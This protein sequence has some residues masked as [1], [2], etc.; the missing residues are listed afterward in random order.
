MLAFAPLADHQPAM[1]D[2]FSGDLCDYLPFSLS[3]EDLCQAVLH[4]G[5]SIPTLCQRLGLSERHVWQDL[6]LGVCGRYTVQL[7][8]QALGCS[9][10]RF[11]APRS[12]LHT[13]RGLE[14]GVHET[15]IS[16]HYSTD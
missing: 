14:A 10:H 4:R 11:V 13:R 1:N 2:C 9:S 16:H 5:I 12:D 6:R 3:S 15:V 8:L 7:W